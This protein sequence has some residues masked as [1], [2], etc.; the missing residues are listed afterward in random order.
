MGLYTKIDNQLDNYY[1]IVSINK[2]L[3]KQNFY[4][5]VIILL[6]LIFNV[7]MIIREKITTMKWCL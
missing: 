2:R 3:S 1:E 4:L 5:K 7:F 6:L